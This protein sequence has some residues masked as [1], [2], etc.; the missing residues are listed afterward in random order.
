MSCLYCLCGHV[1]CCRRTCCNRWSQTLLLKEK[2]NVLYSFNNCPAHLVYVYISMPR[3]VISCHIWEIRRWWIY[4][5]SD[6]DLLHAQCHGHRCRIWMIIPDIPSI[7]SLAVQK[8]KNVNIWKPSHTPTRKKV[9]A[10]ENERVVPIGVKT[11]IIGGQ[12]ITMPCC[13]VHGTP[14]QKM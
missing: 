6:I 7:S 1:L 9:N 11:K 14:T 13:C 3:K 12:Q 4:C 8:K 5:S 10:E 2:W